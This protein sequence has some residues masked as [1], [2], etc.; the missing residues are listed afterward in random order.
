MNISPAYLVLIQMITLSLEKRQGGMYKL[1]PV[2]VENEIKLQRLK[3]K[4]FVED[5][6]NESPQIQELFKEM[7]KHLPQE[8]QQAYQ[9]TQRFQ[10]LIEEQ[11]RRKT[12]KL[13]P[14]N[15]V[16]EGGKPWGFIDVWLKDLRKEPIKLL[17][18]LPYKQCKE[19]GKP[20]TLKRK[21]GY[22]SS[23]CAKAY[24]QWRDNIHDVA[25]TKEGLAQELYIRE[26]AIEHYKIRKKWPR[27]VTVT[28]AAWKIA[29]QIMAQTK[30]Y[31]EPEVPIVYSVQRFKI[32]DWLL[33]R[34]NQ[35]RVLPE[36]D[37]P[38][39]K[40]KPE[41]LECYLSPHFMFEYT[42]TEKKQKEGKNL[43]A[44]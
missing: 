26:K 11:E 38:N 15:E 39:L 27:L 30:E 28:E 25:K 4:Q 40:A 35:R 13:E 43:D 36:K 42:L 18:E 44:D 2:V 9:Y 24:Y 16:F 23:E 8:I 1:D 3:A 33:N 20:I 6:K 19:C 34:Y 7:Q 12:F 5:L 37:L 17:C 29:C 31:N 22:C 32:V 21:K 14:P 41:D 10:K